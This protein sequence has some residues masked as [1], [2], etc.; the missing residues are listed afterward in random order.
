MWIDLGPVKRAACRSLPV[1]HPG[2][3]LL[4][5]QPDRLDEGIFDALTPSFLRLLLSAHSD[6]LGSPAAGGTARG[7]EAA[8]HGD[9]TRF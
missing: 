5:A 4:V 7:V 1:G 2:R 6:R 3:E 8:E 9:D